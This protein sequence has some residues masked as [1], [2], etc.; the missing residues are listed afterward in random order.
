MVFS[1]EGIKPDKSKLE[2]TGKADTPK[3]AKHLRRFLG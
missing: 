2:E 3:N 1:K